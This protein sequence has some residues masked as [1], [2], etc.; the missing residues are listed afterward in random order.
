VQAFVANLPE[1]FTV[2][3]VFD[4]KRRQASIKF[5]PSVAA[6]RRGPWDDVEKDQ[7]GRTILNLGGGCFQVLDDP[8]AVYREIFE[9]YTQFVVQCTIAF[10]KR[11]GRELP[12]VGEIR[13]RFAY[14]RLREHQRRDPYAF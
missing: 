10:S 5:R 8:S 1:P 6:A 13:S 14:L 11:K 4:E 12:W 9:T 7:I 2:N 3:P